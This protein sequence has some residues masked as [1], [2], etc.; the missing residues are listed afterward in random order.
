V[1]TASIIPV[2]MTADLTDLTDCADTPPAVADY[3]S[4]WAVL[5]SRCVA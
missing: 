5:L 4:S 2:N 3:A 1:P